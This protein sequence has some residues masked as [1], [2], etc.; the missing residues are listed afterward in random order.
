MITRRVDRV[1]TSPRQGSA[2]RGDADDSNGRPCDASRCVVTRGPIPERPVA[3]PLKRLTAI[4]TPNRPSRN[5][6]VGPPYL[7]THHLGGPPSL[8]QTVR[9]LSPS[10]KD[11]V[12]PDGASCVEG[13]SSLVISSQAAGQHD[14]RLR[15]RSDPHYAVVGDHA[16]QCPCDRFSLGDVQVGTEPARARTDGLGDVESI[17]PVLFLSVGT[18][19]LVRRDRFVAL[20]LEAHRRWRCCDASRCQASD[21]LWIRDRTPPMSPSSSKNCPRAVL[22]LSWLPL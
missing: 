20:N 22:P 13:S 7:L 9:D 6:R 19:S 4:R 5:R 17:R 12:L 10:V 14:E 16:C 21:R 8:K 1:D 11:L 2:W 15:A 18:L 3:Y